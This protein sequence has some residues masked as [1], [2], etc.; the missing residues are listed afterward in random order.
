[1]KPVVVADAG[2]LIALAKLQQLD[3]LLKLFSKIHIP[4]AVFVEATQNQTRSD[5]R[6]IRS[7][8]TKHLMLT[9][10]S[11]DPLCDKLRKSL[12]EGET[13]AL[14]LAKK[15]NC[16]VLMDERKGRQIARYYQ[17][18]VVGVLG[19]LLQAKR[20]GYVTQ[21]RSLA[22]Q[23]QTSGYRLSDELIQSVLQQAGE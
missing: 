22:E 16:A 4:D 7:F 17:I 8:T 14:V 21:I 20:E 18:S 9:P 13:Q 11:T 2:P 19:V 3:L 12:H 10:A 15:L 6:S 1:M 23:L 5:A